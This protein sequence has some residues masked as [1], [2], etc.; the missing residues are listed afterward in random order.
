MTLAAFAA[1][2]S[3]ACTRDQLTEITN[4]LFDNSISQVYHKAYNFTDIS[5]SVISKPLEINHNFSIV[6]TTT[7]ATLTEIII[8]DPNTPYV[9]GTQTHYSS[10]GKINKVEGMVT[11]PGIDEHDKRGRDNRERIHAVANIYADRFNNAS[12]EVPWSIPCARLEGGAGG[13]P[14]TIQNTDRRIV[15]DEILGVVNMFTKYEDSHSFKVEQGSLRHVHT[16]TAKK[17]PSTGG[18]TQHCNTGII[19]E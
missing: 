10:D 17:F 3:A 18:E 9:I 1:A 11:N 4:N 5:K 12:I 15:V 8:A 16:L 19:L 13:M 7:C 2:V 6:D 14:D